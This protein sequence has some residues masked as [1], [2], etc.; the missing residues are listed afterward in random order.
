MFRNKIYTSKI[1]T[2]S[3]IVHISLNNNKKICFL[4]EDT[5]VIWSFEIITPDPNI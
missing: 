5:T 3:C 2:K 1:H 4:L